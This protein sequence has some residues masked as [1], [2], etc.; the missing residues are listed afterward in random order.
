MGGDSAT[1]SGDLTVDTDT[2]YVDST[3]D[4]VGI[5]GGSPEC[6][7]QVYSS[8]VNN[9]FLESSNATGTQVFIRNS[10]VAAGV[11]TQLGF[12]PANNIF[13]GAIVVTS[14]ED[15]SSEAA[16]TAHMELQTRHNGTNRSRLYLD[17]NNTV[18]NEDGRDTDFRVASDSNANAIFLDAGDGRLGLFTGSPL[19]KFQ[20]GDFGSNTSKSGQAALVES[21]G[22]TLNFDTGGNTS[23]STHRI[24]FIDRHGAASQGTDGQIGA[25]IEASRDATSSTFELNLG[26]VNNNS[27][28]AGELLSITANNGIIN[29]TYPVVEMTAPQL[30][31]NRTDRG[32]DLKKWRLAHSSEHFEIQALNDAESAAYSAMKFERT[33][34]GTTTTIVNPDSR[35]V[36]DFQVKSASNDHMLFV[37]AGNDYIGIDTSNPVA[38]LVV[39]NGGASGIEFQP[40]IS[41]NFNR[42]TNFNRSASVYNE[43]G[44]D[45]ARIEIRPEGVRRLSVAT[46]GV[47]VNADGR[48]DTDFR[49]ESVSNDH[50][51]FVDAGSDYVGINQSSPQAILD[52]KGN[53]TTYAG[54]S[55]IYLT[56]VS[57]N[58]SSRN[59]AIGNGGSDYGNFTIGVS[60]VATGDP[61]AAGTHKT[62]FIIQNSGSVVIN[63]DDND[64]DFRVES[65]NNTQALW[66]DAANDV[67]KIGGSGEL[68]PSMVLQLLGAMGLM[69]SFTVNST[70]SRI[71]EGTGGLFLCRDDSYGGVAIVLYEFSSTPT[72]IAQTASNFITSGTPTGTQ[73]KFTA[74]SSPAPFGMKA[75]MASGQS[76]TLIGGA[77]I[78]DPS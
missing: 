9:T 55:K 44:I 65:V 13:G 25:Y 15:F 2:L 68:N 34:T 18:F 6:S 17:E 33:A 70:E 36:G 71:A 64:A 12:A 67:V 24:N 27:G 49:V 45:A 16:R 57:G 29:K 59:W 28:D 46:S 56:D 40:E 76:T 39:S 14:D 77:I 51:F 30:I 52:I 1:I 23:G 54:M 53:T 38:T 43:L 78:C 32:T 7:L 74:G 21:S 60:N 58:A 63:E 62:P 8:D 75:V 72:I 66:V 19:V 22:F 26:A 50:M 11:Y 48:T 3:N 20:I 37:D 4:R 5:N 41:T 31:F 61:M 69:Q 47:I 42:I 35:N 73:V 10:T